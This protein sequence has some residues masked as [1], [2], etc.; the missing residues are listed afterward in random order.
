MVDFIVSFLAFVIGSVFYLTAAAVLVTLIFT[1]YLVYA[2][3]IYIIFIFTY[4]VLEK[5]VKKKVVAFMVTPVVYM[6]LFFIYGYYVFHTPPFSSSFF[7]N[8][9]FIR[10]VVT[11]AHLNYPNNLDP[12]MYRFLAYRYSETLKQK[13]NLTKKQKEIL[14]KQMVQEVLKG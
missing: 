1:G 8:E 6:V 11:R 3:F 12:F 10:Q 7:E 4:L 14:W 13:P 5:I 9:K 2:I